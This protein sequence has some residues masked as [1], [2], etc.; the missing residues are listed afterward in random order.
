MGCSTGGG[1]GSH[2]TIIVTSD[3]GKSWSAV[4]ASLGP[5]TSNHVKAN[6]LMRVKTLAGGQAWVVG[7]G[8]DFLHSSDFGNTWTQEGVDEDKAWNDIFFLNGK[9]WLVGEFG[10]IKVSKDGGASWKDVTSPVQNSLMSVVFKDDN[11]G[12]AVGLNGNVIVSHDGGKTWTKTDPVSKEHLLDV[13]WD[14][15][16]WVATGA[17]GIIVIGDPDAR[18]WR[19]TRLSADDRAWYTAI[20]KSNGWYYLAGARFNKKE[21]LAL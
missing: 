4:K 11:N 10:R 1:G 8:S 6:K 9:G 16:R 20:I 5:E 12:V 14:G 17:K 3:A 2:G 19:M 13:I 18:E 15:S 21:A 7:E